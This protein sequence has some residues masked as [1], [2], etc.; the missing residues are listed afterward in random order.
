MLATPCKANGL[1]YIGKTM[2][3]TCP[4]CPLSP[5]P[6]Q[7]WQL[8]PH[9]SNHQREG[10]GLDLNCN[11][12]ATHLRGG[13]CRNFSCGNFCFHKVRY[14][15]SLRDSAIC[16]A[17][18]RQESGVGLHLYTTALRSLAVSGETFLH[19]S[20]SWGPVRSVW[21]KM[22]LLEILPYLLG[23]FHLPLLDLFAAFKGGI[24]GG[25]A[26]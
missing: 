21:K 14:R 22:K 18:L 23:C 10:Q 12:L 20:P 25:W 19:F 17:R 26:A 13:C 8:Y 16:W 24:L 4:P 9:H 1:Q 2:A 11:L 15:D 6:P 3:L 7:S 5:L